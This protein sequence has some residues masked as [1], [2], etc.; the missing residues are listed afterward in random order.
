MRRDEWPRRETE[1]GRVVL[2]LVLG[3]AL[4]AG[5]AYVAAYL[6]AGDKVP[7]GTTIAGVDIGGHGPEAAAQVLR[8]GLSQ[9][10]STPFTV[11]INGRSQQVRPEQ[12]GLAV[13][14][15]ASVRKAG[16]ERSWRPSHLWGY[17]TD[18]GTYRPVVTL[19]QTRLARLLRRLDVTDGRTPTDGGVV[20]G[21]HSF[22]VR[23][24]R[25]GYTIDPRSAGAAFWNAYLT[26]SPSVELRLSPVAPAIDGTAVHHFVRRFAN[27]ALASPVELRLGS[28]QLRLSPSD[29]AHLLV[30]RRVGNRLRPAVRAGPLMQ[31]AR[32]DLA[33][34]T[35][36]RPRPATVTLRHGRPHVVPS[37]PGV[38]F[39]P[40]D[41]GAALLQAIASPRRTARV[42]STPA[43]ASFS[44][45]DARRLGIRER[46]ASYS[47]GLGPAHGEAV[48]RAAR[49]L[50]GAVVLPGH[51]LSLR[52][53]L[54]TA[55]PR[56]HSADVVAT[57]LFNAA[58]LGG[59]QVSSHVAA[60]S[61]A[62]S[63]PVGR[64]ASLRDGSDLSV[65]DDSRY[66]VL[67]A[68]SSSGG[69]LTVTL[70]STRRWT[71][72]SHAGPRRHVVR[73]ARHVDGSAGCTPRQGR[74]GFDVTV[75]RSL[76]QQG[77]SDRTTS[78]T[79]HYAPRAAVVCRH[80]RHHHHH[81]H[82]H[83]G[84]HRHHRRV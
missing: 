9:R 5:G 19:D 13:D 49:A 41:V 69:R 8:E 26:D 63:V 15:D 57:A 60:A 31:L 14:Y 48:A 78:F 76:V 43:R 68:A 35:R 53:R 58:W 71:V 52:A 28:A 16:G 47:V 59:L 1:G 37:R 67:V 6:A 84:H 2:A 54:G 33:A 46:L 27:P 75:T 73:A 44:T 32:S 64:D 45:R 39:R 36:D 21:H 66:G 4:L 22:T 79:V 77:E 72:T 61:Y 29:Y 18:G 42:R 81:H 30:A 12:V 20:F 23:P 74:D 83:H 55:V 51:T 80:D 11:V 34:D 70:W 10:A 40:K 65:R 7:V 38:R 62:G 25:S 3:L 56:G 50:D 17:F 24:P 82:H